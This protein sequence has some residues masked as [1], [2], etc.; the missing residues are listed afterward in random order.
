MIKNEEKIYHYTNIEA[1]CG[2][3]KTNRLRFSSCSNYKDYEAES[4]EIRKVVCRNMHNHETFRSVLQDWFKRSKGRESLNNCEVVDFIF[5]MRNKTFMACFSEVVDNNHLWNKYAKEGQGVVIGFKRNHILPFLGGKGSVSLNGR[6]ADEVRTCRMNYDEANFRESI[7]GWV[8]QNANLVFYIDAFK[9]YKYKDEK[10]F[11]CLVYINNIG[12]STL[13]KIQSIYYD[14]ETSGGK[15]IVRHFNYNNEGATLGLQISNVP[16]LGDN[17]DS[18]IA[19]KHIYCK[20]DETIKRV[21]NI[22]EE[23]SLDSLVTIKKI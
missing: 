1:L 5:E 16:L 9:G 19:I 14:H 21:R 13:N 8:G 22:L 7:E 3:V 11:R 15:K 23:Y 20:C 4:D 2:I 10:E 17:Y 18:S 12:N 6:R